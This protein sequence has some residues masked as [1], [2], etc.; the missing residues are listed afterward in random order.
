MTHGRIFEVILVD[1]VMTN[2]GSS[3]ITAA[4]A[5][6]DFHD[7]QGKVIASLQQSVGGIPPGG[8]FVQNQFKG[9]P[10]QPKEIRFFRLRVE[11]TPPNW[12]L[13]IPELKIVE[14]KAR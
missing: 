3:P 5:E 4:T 10:L 11:K 6:L 14:V 12:N 8:G 2:A 7:A 9:N 13:E 1:G